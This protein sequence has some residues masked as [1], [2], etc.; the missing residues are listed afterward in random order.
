MAQIDHGI[1]IPPPARSPKYPEVL[2]LGVGDSVWYPMAELPEKNPQA[3]FTNKTYCRD[4]RKYVSRQW[5][6]HG[7]PDQPIIPDDELGVRVWRIK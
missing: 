6:R 1:P 7:K 2:Q 5:S 3:P 4:D